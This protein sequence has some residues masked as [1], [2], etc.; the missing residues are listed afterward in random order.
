LA[1]RDFV[2]SGKIITLYPIVSADDITQRR[3]SPY[4]VRVGWTSSQVNHPLADWIIKNTSYRKI[5][6]IGFDFAFGHEN[7]GGFQRTFE[8]GGGR[9]VQKLW[10]PIGAPDYGAAMWTLRMSSS[11]EP[12][13]CGF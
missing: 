8:E 2:D 9:V 10:P 11:P 13:R 6:T 5:A 4:I 12:T 7:V 1:L 3:S